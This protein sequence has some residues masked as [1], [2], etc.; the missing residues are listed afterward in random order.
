MFINRNGFAWQMSAGSE[1]FAS[2]THPKVGWH[3]GKEICK[4][5]PAKK[6]EKPWFRPTNTLEKQPGFHQPASRPCNTL[7]QPAKTSYMKTAFAKTPAY[8]RWNRPAVQCPGGKK[9]KILTGHTRSGVQKICANALIQ[10]CFQTW[11]KKKKF[12]STENRGKPVK[13]GYTR[14]RV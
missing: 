11:Y 10:L 12:F 13:D 6:D 5:F 7:V 9:R 2:V 8:R 3:T 4:G 1:K 14:N